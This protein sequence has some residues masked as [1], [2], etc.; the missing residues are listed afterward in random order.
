M[1]R[2]IRLL[3]KQELCNLWGMNQI[4][5]SRNRKQRNRLLLLL[6]AYAISGGVLIAYI[7]II[8]YV[9]VLLSMEKT[10]PVYLTAV[11]SMILFFF[12]ALKA[13]SMIFDIRKYEMTAPLPV[14]PASIV[15]S[16]F[17]AMYV[18]DMGLC[19]AVMAPAVLVYGFCLRPSAGFYGGMLLGAILI[20][21]LPLCAAA[22]VGALI[23]AVSSRMK[24]RNLV[25]ILLTMALTIGILLLCTGGQASLEGSL[26]GMTEGDLQNI[27]DLAEQQISN[28]YPP[29]GWLG[30]GIMQGDAKAFVKLMLVS[31]VPLGVLVA[32]VQW[33]FAELCRALNARSSHSNYQ[34]KELTVRSSLKALY[35]RELKRYFSSVIY[36]TNTL[37]GYLLMLVIAAGICFGGIEKIDEL[38]GITGIVVPILPLLFG[39]ICA[40]S[41]TTVSSISMEGKQWWIAKS[42]PVTTGQ[43]FDSK[44]LV[45]LTVGL[46]CIAV[47]DVLL[48]IS[49][50]N[51]FW[52]YVW[53]A[54]V[55]AAYLLFMS[56]L[57]IAINCRM[58]LLRWE[59]EAAVIKQSGAVLCNM[60]IGMASG[61]LPMIAVLLLP[62][63]MTNPVMGLVTAAVLAASAL[64][65]RGSRRTDLRTIE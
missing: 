16:R 11:A 62:A 15:I 9:L 35:W 6:A 44:I 34:L 8:S 47:S 20:P 27:A 36:V 21:L 39:V 41:S 40:M 54:I 48:F 1:R 51:T 45:N 32:L 38:F 50:E 57:G 14:R 28:I 7:G 18:Q 10:I 60:L 31:F 23:T 64:I 12:N 55:P 3:L 52:G 26:A 58:P 46:P 22:A 63:S 30:R 17:A 42:L 24:H 29:A 49:V 2:E 4:K 59:S 53:M 61:I 19:L 43:L 25:T 65:Y 37:I 5:Y 56:V 33:K 13:G